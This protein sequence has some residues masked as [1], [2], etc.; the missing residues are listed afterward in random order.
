MRQ[1]CGKERAHARITQMTHMPSLQPLCI[2]RQ[3]QGSLL[4]WAI[5]KL[6][7]STKVPPI[8]VAPIQEC[9]KFG[10]ANQQVARKGWDM[11]KHLFCHLLQHPLGPSCI[12]NGPVVKYSHCSG[13]PPW[14]E[15]GG[16]GRRLHAYAGCAPSH[17]CKCRRPLF[18]GEYHA[19]SVRKKKQMC[20]RVRRQFPGGRAIS[21][22]IPKST[23][24]SFP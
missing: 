20:V 6:S 5:N 19:G 7:Q 1:L 21:E 2:L 24:T 10:N 3:N 16:L 15:S 23:S 22:V 4:H 9:L 17:K 18:F 8:W 11:L 14:M 13:H 12:E